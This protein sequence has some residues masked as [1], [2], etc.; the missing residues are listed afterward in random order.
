MDIAGLGSDAAVA[1]GVHLKD[2]PKV[3]DLGVGGIGVDDHIG[4]GFG[5]GAVLARNLSALFTDGDVLVHIA[6]AGVE[7]H[8]EPVGYR[9]DAAGVMGTGVGGELSGNPAYGDLLQ[10]QG[11][12][13]IGDDI[14][15]GK[16]LG[17][18]DVGHVLLVDGSAGGAAVGI[19]QGLV[20]IVSHPDGRGIVGVDT[21]E[22]N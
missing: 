8:G 18:Q 13:G 6:G 10:P 11:F 20:V 16:L 7:L 3:G 21:A 5:L 14:R 15:V 2:R 9:A 22:G 4:S 12:R 19:P 1:D 17:I